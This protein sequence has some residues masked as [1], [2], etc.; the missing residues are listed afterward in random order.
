MNYLEYLRTWRGSRNENLYSR[1]IIA[2]LVAANVALGYGLM[3]KRETVVPIPFTLSQAERVGPDAASSGFKE[4]WGLQVA[5]LVGNVTPTS[6]PFL[7]DHLSKLASPS[8]FGA[9]RESLARETKRLKEEGIS[10]Q[11]T[12]ID[13]FYDAQSDVVVVT[14]QYI[15][16]G[17]RSEERS[18]VRTYEIGVRVENYAARVDSL[19]SY[20]GAWLSPEQ[21]L[22]V[23]RKGGRV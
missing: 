2:G 21:K 17:V 11:F 8:A 5:L 18:E 19:T 14:G 23:A 16:R 1:F 7:I 22:E 13:T 6:A 9:I 15:A 12:P 20:E 10:I 3:M 4:A